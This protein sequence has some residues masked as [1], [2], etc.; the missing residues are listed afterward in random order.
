MAKPK[1]EQ[2]II[3]CTDKRGVFFGYV[4]STPQQ[5]LADKAVTLKRARMCVHWSAATK[6]VLGLA[7]S[8]PAKGS[9]VTDAIPSICLD[10]IHA[11]LELT[12]EAIGRWE[13]LPWL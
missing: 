7:A 6:G 1:S 12:P 5:V 10:G 11:V 4:D 8:G 2:A 3:V 13:N 9:K